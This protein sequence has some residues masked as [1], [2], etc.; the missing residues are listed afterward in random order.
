[1]LTATLAIDQGI[2]DETT[3]NLQSQV[4]ARHLLEETF[5][6]LQTADAPDPFLYEIEYYGYSQ[7]GFGYLGYE[8]EAIAGYENGVDDNYWVLWVNDEPATV[9]IDSYMVQPGDAV[10]LVYQN[11]AAVAKTPAAERMKHVHERRTSR[12]AMRAKGR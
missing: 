2:L 3:V 8:V 4:N 6:Q 12:A 10:Q 11:F 1:M 5:V 7:G 9:G